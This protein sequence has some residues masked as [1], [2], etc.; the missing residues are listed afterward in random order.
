M[1]SILARDLTPNHI[2]KTVTVNTKSGATISDELTRISAGIGSDQ[3]GL[4]IPSVSVGFKRTRCVI[5]GSYFLLDA[6]A[7]VHFP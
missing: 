1:I 6:D 7:V 4:V 3:D 2:G 5:A